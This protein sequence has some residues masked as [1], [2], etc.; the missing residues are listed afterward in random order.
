MSQSGRSPKQSLEDLKK[1]LANARPVVVDSTGKLTTPDE[2]QARNAAIAEKQGLPAPN[3]TQ[4]KPSRW[5]GC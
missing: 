1:Q 5:F 3:M 2:V 4:L